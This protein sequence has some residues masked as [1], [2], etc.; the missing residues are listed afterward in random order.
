MQGS[1]ISLFEI[2]LSFLIKKLCK[3]ESK[4]VNIKFQKMEAPKL[5]DSFQLING[6]NISWICQNFF[7]FNLSIAINLWQKA[8]N[9]KHVI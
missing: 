1:N 8:F 5:K 6:I 2:K 9:V 7:Y 3:N 4:I